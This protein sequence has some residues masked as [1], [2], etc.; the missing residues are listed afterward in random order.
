M[1]K[2]RLLKDLPFLKAGSIFSKDFGKPDYRNGGYYFT[3]DEIKDPEWFEEVGDGCKHLKV[4]NVTGDYIKYNYYDSYDCK[5][6]KPAKQ[7]PSEWIGV[8]A[9]ELDHTIYKTPEQQF[10]KSII[11]FLDKHFKN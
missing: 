5:E 11:D 1:K 7:K 2:Y 10:L 8:R 4:T 9:D 3:E 6:F